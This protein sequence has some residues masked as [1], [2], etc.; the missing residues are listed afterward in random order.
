MKTKL[1]RILEKIFPYNTINHAQNTAN[2][3]LL[4]RIVDDFNQAKAKKKQKRKL[5]KMQQD[6]KK[7]KKQMKNGKRKI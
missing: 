1:K 6:I 2:L 3:K 7:L 4:N 5:K